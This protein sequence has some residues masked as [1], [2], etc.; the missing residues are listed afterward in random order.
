MGKRFWICG[1]VMF[2]AAMLLAFV[3]HAL[4]LG[5]DYEALGALYRDAEDGRRH[6][7][8]MLLAHAL[9]GF[10]MTWIF[11]QGFDGREATLAQGLR[12]GAAMALF[13]TVPGYLIH[14]AVQPLPTALVAKQV[15][16]GTLSMLL[17]GALLAW[18][19]PRRPTLT[20]PG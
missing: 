2:F 17:L 11:A 15:V 20:L 9:I 7:P 3:V 16:F 14:Y 18:L 10:A 1:L 13:S 12:F 4:L 19:Q 5:A 8:W 6:F